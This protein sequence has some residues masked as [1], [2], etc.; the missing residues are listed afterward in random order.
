MDGKGDVVDGNQMSVS[1][2]EVYNRYR[3]R[4]VHD[5]RAQRAGVG[6]IVDIAANIA[7][8]SVV[9]RSLGENR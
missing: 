2:D 5:G 1:L 9:Y 4:R 7:F 6:R 8:R 3:R